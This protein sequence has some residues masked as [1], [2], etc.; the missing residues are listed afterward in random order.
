MITIESYCNERALALIYTET[1]T[2]LIFQVISKL[3]RLMLS[4]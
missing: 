2:T 3:D 4:R 1:K